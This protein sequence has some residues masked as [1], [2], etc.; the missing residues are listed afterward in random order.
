[1]KIK[2]VL[3]VLLLSIIIGVFNVPI[4]SMA[5]YN[6][7]VPE[8]CSGNIKYKINEKTNEAIITGTKNKNVKKIVIPSKIDEYKVTEIGYYAFGDYKNLND[9]TIPNTVKKINGEAFFNCKKIKN[10]KI[11]NSVQLIGYYAFFG[12][13]GL[14]K[15]E[16]PNSVTTLEN[17]AFE[18]CSNLKSVKLSENLK[19]IDGY[20]FYG[21]KKL[22]SVEVQKKVK[23]IGDGA[24][25]ECKKLKQVKIPSSVKEIGVDVFNNCN[26]NLV[27]IV[28][29]KSYSQKYAKNNK[30]NY[31]SNI[32][33]N[34][35]ISWVKPGKKQAK[36]KWNKI[37]GVTGYGIYM[38]TSKNGK[39]SKIKTIKN[40]KTVTYTKTN[41]KKNKKYY[42]KV[43]AYKV[44][45]EQ[46]VY[47]EFSKVQKVT[48]K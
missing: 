23:V 9:V 14:E 20:A 21:C 43:R 48:I 19:A 40:A 26:T 27:L 47:G 25:G 13:S 22:T 5:S 36:I 6:P 12:C 24:F 38:S 41:L 33:K 17:M 39:Y 42:F 31:E 28:E 18:S 1:M 16:L 7:N 11:P 15:I 35:K 32:T 37:S 29:N 34:L 10:I 30:I 8:Y 46:K 4:K 2:K 45:N 3:L 44:I